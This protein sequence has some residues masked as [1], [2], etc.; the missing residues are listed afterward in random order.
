MPVC[1]ICGKNIKNPNSL[2]HIRSKYHQEKLKEKLNKKALNV[3]ICERCGYELN[4]EWR[5]CPTCGLQ[6]RG[7]NLKNEHKKL[8][9]EKLNSFGIINGNN[10]F[11]EFA[12]KNKIPGI[13][14][15]ESPFILKGLEIGNTKGDN[16]IYINNTDCFLII[17]DCIIKNCTGSGISL[18]SVKN[19]VI[20]RNKIVSND[21]FGI[22][23]YNSSNIEVE[24]N[25]ILNNNESGILLLNSNE[26]KIRKNKIKLNNMNGIHRYYSSSNLINQNKLSNHETGI[27]LQFS[28]NNKI[29][30]NISTYNNI[31]ISIILS[32]KNII[33][34][35]FTNYNNKGI[36]LARSSENIIENNETI[37]NNKSGIY[38]MGSSENSIK[39]NKTK[40]NNNYEIYSFKIK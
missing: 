19:V 22:F 29:I 3:R 8:N 7:D 38:L 15:A 23:L 25:E 30:N 1:S 32:N 18:K 21:K 2:N 33:N 37:N 20:K 12:K 31:G 14:T 9:I 36:S 34:N 10:E 16:G 5:F 27:E 4:K 6:L 39:N 40:P 11:K 13:G 17:Q 26:N 35:N 28:K 24:G